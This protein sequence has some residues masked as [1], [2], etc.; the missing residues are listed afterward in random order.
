VEE[1]V[2]MMMTMHCVG[3]KVFGATRYSSES[4]CVV[5]D[6][7]VVASMPEYWP[8]MRV[9]VILQCV[10][11]STVDVRVRLDPR[12]HLCRTKKCQQLVELIR[13]VYVHASWQVELVDGLLRYDSQSTVFDHDEFVAT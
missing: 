9:A 8:A 12:Q 7:V 6:H 5:V 3:S 2:V 1:E 11:Q 13:T 4:C 10:S